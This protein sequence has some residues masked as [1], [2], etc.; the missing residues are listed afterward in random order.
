M[1]PRDVLQLLF[2]KN[3]KVDKITQQPLRLEKKISTDLESSEFKKIFNVHLTKFKN[4][5][6][7]LNIISHRILLTTKVY[8]LGE[9]SSLTK[10]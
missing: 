10:R 3:H 6:I 7:L 5:Q 2:C 8:L 9:R 4:N 1:G